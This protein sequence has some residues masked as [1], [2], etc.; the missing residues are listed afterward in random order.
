MKPKDF[1][2]KKGSTYYGSVKVRLRQYTY[3]WLNLV[4]LKLQYAYKIKDTTSNY[5]TTENVR[6]TLSFL[7]ITSK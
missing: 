6:R 7:V 4:I 5:Q 3:Q 1:K 2:P